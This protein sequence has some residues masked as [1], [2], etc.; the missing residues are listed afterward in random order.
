MISSSQ[1]PDSLPE[2]E[3]ISSDNEKY[4]LYGIS[5]Y[6]FDSGLPPL[7]PA[8]QFE[9]DSRQLEE[10]PE[11]TS[12]PKQSP[13]RHNSLQNITPHK[14]DESKRN[15]MKPSPKNLDEFGQLQDPDFGIASPLR[16]RAI[17]TSND[18][19]GTSNI[20]LARAQVLIGVPSNSHHQG[21]S[22][23]QSYCNESFK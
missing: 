4:V 11:I 17:P 1:A 9:Y 8:P 5:K 6:S 2:P 13:E 12:I 16:Q 22:S 10:E 18:R 7:P 23:R 21:T 20:L 3:V 15:I 14:T 19:H